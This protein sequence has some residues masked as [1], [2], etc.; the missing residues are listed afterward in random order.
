MIELGFLFEKKVLA[1]L[2]QKTTFALM[3]FVMKTSWFFQ[4]TFQIKNLKFHG[5]ITRN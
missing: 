1:K 2:K 5:F 4:F 3:S